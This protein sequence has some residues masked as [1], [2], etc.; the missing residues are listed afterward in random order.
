MNG[1]ISR[2]GH[3]YGI[4]TP[5]NDS[6]ADMVIGKSKLAISA[7]IEAKRLD[8]YKVDDVVY[9]PG[10]RRIIYSASFGATYLPKDNVARKSRRPED[11]R[12]PEPVS[13]KAHKASPRI[14]RTQSEP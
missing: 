7:S 5:V 2:L 13:G 11:R 6:L 1:Y 9:M 12:A 8:Q 3:Q 14:Q 4:A 10:D